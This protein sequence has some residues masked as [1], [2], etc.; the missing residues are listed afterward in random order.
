MVNFLALDAIQSLIEKLPATVDDRVAIGAS[1]TPPNDTVIQITF[2]T[3]LDK[4]PQRST[5]T[6]ALWRR[7]P[8][9]SLSRRTTRASKHDGG[10]ETDLPLCSSPKVASRSS[11]QKQI[12][13]N[14][15]R[16]R[17]LHRSHPHEQV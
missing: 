10:V 6:Q 8:A 15:D 17:H 14:G 9:R 1:R 11:R 13:R 12:A 4:E 16:L 2:E 5:L 7:D 3:G